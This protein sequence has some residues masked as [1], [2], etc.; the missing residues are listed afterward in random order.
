MSEMRQ[1]IGRIIDELIIFQFNA[2]AED[3]HMDLYR[4]PDGMEICFTS[5]CSDHQDM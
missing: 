2:G 4:R 5:Q 3:I 1:K